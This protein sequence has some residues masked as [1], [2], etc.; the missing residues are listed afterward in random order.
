MMVDDS[1]PLRPEQS[2]I[3]FKRMVESY[4]SKSALITTNLDHECWY[5]FLDQKQMVGALLDRLRSRYHTIRI[6]GTFLWT[7]MT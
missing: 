7:P 3:F 1:C 6:E 5:D 4:N 2:N